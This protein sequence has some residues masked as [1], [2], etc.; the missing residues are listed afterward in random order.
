MPD[1]SNDWHTLVIVRYCSR[2]DIAEI[3]VGNA[4][5]DASRHKW[6]GI[7]KTNAWGLLAT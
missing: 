7:R 6:A 5:A 3:F 4:F 2:L 1:N